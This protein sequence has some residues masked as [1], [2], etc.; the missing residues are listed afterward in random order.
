MSELRIYWIL[1]CYNAWNRTNAFFLNFVH[2]ELNCVKR[3]QY[4]SLFMPNMLRLAATFWK[5]PDFL[6][7]TRM[8]TIL[9]LWSTS[10][11]SIIMEENSRASVWTSDKQWDKVSEMHSNHPDQN[12]WY[13][14]FLLCSN[15]QKSKTWSFGT[16]VRLFTR[17]AFGQPTGNEGSI[18]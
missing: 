6:P 13:R 12:F 11:L 5:C 8:P 18:T 7:D 10:Y 16:S 15:I 3:Q 2:L 4:Y 1:L 14:G 9:Q 17:S